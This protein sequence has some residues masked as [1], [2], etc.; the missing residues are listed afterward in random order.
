MVFREVEGFFELNDR[1]PRLIT[2]ITSISFFISD[3]LKYENYIS[4]GICEEVKQPF[5][6]N[7]YPLKNRFYIPYI[8]T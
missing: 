6:K 2:K 5:V 3:S 7:F 4:G 8:E 1:R